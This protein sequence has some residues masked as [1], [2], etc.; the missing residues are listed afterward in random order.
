[1]GGTEIK[2]R[3]PWTCGTKNQQGLKGDLGHEGE[4]TRKCLFHSLDL[5]QVP[6]LPGD[7]AHVPL[8]LPLCLS[9]PGSQ[10]VSSFNPPVNTVGNYDDYPL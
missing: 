7:E 4:R 5:V 2:G 3:D 6:V 8:Q 1:M 9:H 10:D